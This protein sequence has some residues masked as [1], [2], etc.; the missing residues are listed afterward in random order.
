MRTLP[1]LLLLL[2][3][4]CEAAQDRPPGDLPSTAGGQ[5]APRLTPPPPDLV[6]P[7]VTSAAL[8]VAPLSDCRVPSAPDPRSI[9]TSRRL[10]YSTEGGRELFLDVTR[11]AR[12]GP[13]PVIVLLHG[14]GWRR[15]NRHHMTGGM[16]HLAGLGYA[17]VAVDYRL[18]AAPRN[19]FPAAVADARCAVRWLRL[20]AAV[21]DIDADRMAAMGFSAGGH[22]AA[23]LATAHDVEGLD[24]RCPLR[25]VSPRV[26]A[27]VSFFAPFDL[28]PG[29]PVGPGTE[30]VIANFLG[31]RADADPARA[32][33]A[34]PR[35][36]VDR[37]DPP[38]LLVHGQRD[39]TVYIDQARR[40]QR[41]LEDAGVASTLVE[42]PRGAHGFGLFPPRAHH[43]VATCTTLAFLHAALSAVPS[44]RNGSGG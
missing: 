32:A 19:T 4:A 13:H 29:E 37:S 10:V 24:A 27:A 40:M 5:T 33:L 3:T 18:A 43:P 17:A 35:T 36:H 31:T 26:Q 2:A 20:N 42:V 39:E 28:R 7:R 6:D 44:G 41:A 34:S 8:P 25:T 30:R 22:L 15:G 12:P 1:L 38:M 23:M 9:R 11:P 16:R 21:L 14:G